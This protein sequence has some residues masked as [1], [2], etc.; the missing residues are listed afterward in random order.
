[1]KISLFFFWKTS[2][3]F[4]TLNS[5]KGVWQ[6]YSFVVRSSRTLFMDR[7]VM[8]LLELS[9]TLEWKDVVWRNELLKPFIATLEFLPRNFWPRKE[10]AFNSKLIC[11][12]FSHFLIVKNLSSSQTLLY[13]S[14]IV[15]W[16]GFLLFSH[17]LGRLVVNL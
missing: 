11:C 14:E 15:P 8:I 10:F 6:L 5:D 9:V 17:L 12:L 3:D 7:L 1:M 13:R 16:N 2:K 4:L